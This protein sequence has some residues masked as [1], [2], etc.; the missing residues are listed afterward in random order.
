[1]EH[2]QGR[3][4]D[5]AALADLGQAALRAVPAREMQ[6]VKIREHAALRL[7]GGA[8]GEQ[9]R[10]FVGR[11]AAIAHDFAA[12][13]GQ[14]CIGRR[15]AG[16]VHAGGRDEA[17]FLGK[18]DD[19]I[20]LGDGELVG[21]VARLQ[22][23]IDREDGRPEPIERE[24]MGEEI[25]AVLQQEADARA[26]A[27][28]G[29]RVGALDGF[30]LRGRFAV[31]AVDSVAR[32]GQLGRRRREEKR[33]LGIGL[34]AGGEGLVGRVHDVILERPRALPPPACGERV[35]VRGPL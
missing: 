21:E 12:A 7:A 27:V 33:R 23:R 9:Q 2:G 1:M 26:V 5:L 18:R 17:A 4:R 8:G 6:E 30:D 11:R 31:G 15:D 16:G 29:A 13:A 25:R 10:A 34:R 24:P 28:P 20:G 35:G 3:Q 19:E 32:V 14:C 22:V